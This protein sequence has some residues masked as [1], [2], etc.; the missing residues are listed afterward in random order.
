[1]LLRN[2]SHSWTF[3][4][5][6]LRVARL[7]N[8]VGTKDFFQGTNFL[9]KNAPKF[10]PNFL[11]LCFVGPKRSR[12]I[13]AKFPAKFP[14]PKSKKKFTDELLQGVATLR[15]PGKFV[16]L[17]RTP[18]GNNSFLGAAENAPVKEFQKMPKQGGGK[19]KP[20][21]GGGLEIL[22]RRPSTENGFSTPTPSTGGF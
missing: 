1:M 13:P 2:L 3:S 21:N 8:E 15:F 6:F 10:S 14:S 17:W 22:T 20:P 12:K 4:D 9:T 19:G 7:Q 16:S 18:Q 11:S 5:D